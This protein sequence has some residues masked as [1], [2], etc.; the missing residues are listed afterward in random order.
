MTR[1]DGQL[2]C[3][4]Q[5]KKLEESAA[6]MAMSN[7]D[8]SMR[9]ENNPRTSTTSKKHRLRDSKTK[10]KVVGKGGVLD[11]NGSSTLAAGLTTDTGGDSGI[12]RALRGLGNVSQEEGAKV[13]R[14]GEA[15]RGAGDV[16]GD[17]GAPPECRQS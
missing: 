14:R 1:R 2:T 15:V 6:A 3:K 16:A 11:G 4:R 5:E 9:K 8:P 12:R 17:E 10:S 13:S 7:T